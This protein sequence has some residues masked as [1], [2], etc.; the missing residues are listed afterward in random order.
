MNLKPTSPRQPSPEE[1]L[2]ATAHLALAPA[3]DKRAGWTY[4]NAPHAIK[5]ATC[6]LKLAASKSRQ[7][8]INTSRATDQPGTIRARIVQGKAYLLEK[9]TDCLKGNFTS[10]EIELVQS[11]INNLEVSIRRQTISLRLKLESSDYMDAL[12]IVEGGE[13][14]A[15]DGTSQPF[16]EE[17]FRVELI[18]FVNSAAVDTQI[19]FT[20]L[21]K[22]A[23]SYAQTVALQD[24]SI[25]VEQF[26]HLT[27]VMKLTPEAKAALMAV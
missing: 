19:Q 10:E 14:L 22:S 21:P 17:V 4:F 3:P 5:A 2:A 26:D 13:E 16:N 18:N 23:V 27:V 25:L 12:T 9:G 24:D 11:Q 20:N 15:P 1:V 7:A 8:T 6:I